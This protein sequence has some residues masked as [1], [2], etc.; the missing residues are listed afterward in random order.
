MTALTI[1]ELNIFAKISLRIIKEQELVIGPLAWDEAAKVSGLHIIDKAN[2]GFTFD[3]DARE[4][5]NRLVAQYEHLFGKLSRE[6][7][8]EAARD[9]IT[10]LPVDDVPSSLK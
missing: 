4:V 2:G 7:C 9:L 1:D 5:L 8:K 6:V 3:G 10:E